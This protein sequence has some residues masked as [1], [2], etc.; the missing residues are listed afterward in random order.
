MSPTSWIETGKLSGTSELP[1]CGSGLK[2]LLLPFSRLVDKISKNL[3]NHW[4]YLLM[5]NSSCICEHD[6][7]R[8]SFLT[9]LNTPRTTQGSRV[10]SMISSCPRSCLVNLAFWG[11][12]LLHHAKMVEIL[13]SSR[14]SEARVKLF[15]SVGPVWIP[16]ARRV[17]VPGQSNLHR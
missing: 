14:N 11:C 2:A 3:W 6:T 17:R 10:K 7:M 9:F 13:H 16:R 4:E 15:A 1:G 8:S 12:G 5:W